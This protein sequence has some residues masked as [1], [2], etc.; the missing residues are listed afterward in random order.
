LPNSKFGNNLYNSVS[1]EQH[2]YL[3]EQTQKHGRTRE[4]L[5]CA[6]KS[7][8]IKDHSN[9]YESEHNQKVDRIYHL[10]IG[11]FKVEEEG[12]LHQYHLVAVVRF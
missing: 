5:M 1:E 11:V 6:N 8:I 7:I 2:Q 4:Q 10:N 3:K 12:H 9:S